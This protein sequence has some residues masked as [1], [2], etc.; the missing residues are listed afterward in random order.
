MWYIKEDYDLI[1][2]AADIIWIFFK[3]YLVMI[4]LGALGSQISQPALYQTYWTVWLAC[5]VLHLVFKASPVKRW[6]ASQNPKA[7]L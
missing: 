1:A 4:A 6:K 7:L 5:W 3:P 2:V